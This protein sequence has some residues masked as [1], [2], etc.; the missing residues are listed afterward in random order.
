[1]ENAVLAVV[2]LW[3]HLYEQLR[4]TYLLFV[5]S[6]IAPS[7]KTI[8]LRNETDVQ[9]VL[10]AQWSRDKEEKFIIQLPFRKIH[11]LPPRFLR[12]YGWKSDQAI[13]SNMDLRERILGRWTLLGSMT[14]MEPGDR[15]HSAIAFIKDSMTANMPA[16]LDMVHDEIDASLDD[17][18]GRCAGWHGHSAYD[19]AIHLNLKIFER[20]FV[21]LDLCR[22]HEWNV[23]C[24]GYSV[25]AIRTASVLMSYPSW[26]RPLVAPFLPEY[27]H[28]KGHIQSLQAHLEPLLEARLAAQSYEQETPTEPKD[29]IQWWITKAPVDKRSDSYALTVALIQL[30]IAG[31]QSTGMVL[32][33]ALFDLADR[34][35]YIGPL[36]DELKQ[37]TGANGNEHLPP[38]AIARLVKLDSFLKES[39]RHVAQNLLSIYRKVMAPLE[40]MDGS[41]LPTGSY[42][43][44]Q[45]VDPEADPASVSRDFD[46]FRWAKLREKPGN[47]QKFT[48]LASGQESLEFGYGLHACP[49]RFFAMNAVKAS[50][51]AILRK[52][53]LR[54]PP[55]EHM[56]RPRY[57]SLLVLVPPID[58]RVEFRDRGGTSQ[59][60]CT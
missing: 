41:V 57:N 25:S 54:L 12:D 22:N 58:Q 13:S 11:V 15:T 56:P 49:G 28:L 50:L 38:Q 39:Q 43:A 17:Y 21:G 35:E 45:S 60:R 48:T 51:A 29:F 32:M 33:Q 46:A 26:Q 47:A 6:L 55:G 19:F 40:L 2:T 3:R 27:Q 23:A 14:P 53:E 8:D 7:T 1:M 42:V 4:Y 44:V 36:L 20:V 18:P 16:Y 31:I 30:N 5:S 10:H 59:G 9:S 37:T 52:Y 24:R 34:T